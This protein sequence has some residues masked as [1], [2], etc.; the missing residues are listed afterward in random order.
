[1]AGKD[2]MFEMIGCGV[3]LFLVGAGVGLAFWGFSLALAAR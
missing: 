1:M 3:L 2:N